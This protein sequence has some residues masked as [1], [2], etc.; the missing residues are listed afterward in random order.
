MEETTGPLGDV[1]K[2]RKRISYSLDFEKYKSLEQPLADFSPKIE[3]D[4]DKFDSTFYKSS[5]VSKQN[6]LL[7][8]VGIIMVCL[9]L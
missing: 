3:A 2:R 5:Q 9:T 4:L 6:T 7:Y 8:Y 1:I